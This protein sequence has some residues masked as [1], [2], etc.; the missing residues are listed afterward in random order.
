MNVRDQTVRVALCKFVFHVGDFSVLCERYTY[1]QYL[2]RW[3]LALRM[4]NV[5]QITIVAKM[6]DST[7]SQAC[8]RGHVLIPNSPLSDKT[9]Q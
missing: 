5:D 6:N 9:A 2:T 4:L 3:L 8:M 7:Q 1:N